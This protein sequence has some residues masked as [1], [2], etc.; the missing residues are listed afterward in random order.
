LYSAK[1]VVISGTHT[2]SGPGGYLQYVLFL[3]TSKGWIQQSFDALVEGIVQVKYK[4]EK[5]RLAFYEFDEYFSERLILSQ[6]VLIERT[7]T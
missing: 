7:I 3:V 6:R 2:H 1:N 4:Q 5:H